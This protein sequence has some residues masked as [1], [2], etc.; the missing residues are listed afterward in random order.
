MQVKIQVEILS[1]F[2][3]VRGISHV[4]TC[5]EVSRVRDVDYFL[6]YWTHG[7]LVCTYFGKRKSVTGSTF[8]VIND[9]CFEIICISCIYLIQ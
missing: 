1:I 3:H 7:R 6:E 4:N 8:L 2:E 9:E 5:V